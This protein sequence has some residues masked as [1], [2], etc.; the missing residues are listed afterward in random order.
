MT[1]DTQPVTISSSSTS[2]LNNTSGAVTITTGNSNNAGGGTSG[3]ISIGTGSAVGSGNRSGAVAIQT[4]SATG[5]ATRGA[6]S[7]GPNDQSAELF[8]NGYQWPSSDGG[9]SGF[10]ALGTDGSQVLSFFDVREVGT[11]A[12]RV[13]ALSSVTNAT[14]IN[15]N[16]LSR[17][18]EFSLTL[19]EDTT[20]SF[21]NASNRSAF[22]IY[23]TIT[24]ATRTITLPATV[25]MPEDTSNINGATYDNVAG[26]LALDVGTYELKNDYT[27][28]NDLFALTSKY[29]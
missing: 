28:T 26:T 11:P 25:L 18:R 19:N 21:T 20:I 8:L 6:L 2:G 22:R 24:G 9:L 15:F 13:T 17:F 14:A 7:L 12:Q 10:F 16:N 3:G 23:L 27:G 5:G 29:V 4:G 1:S